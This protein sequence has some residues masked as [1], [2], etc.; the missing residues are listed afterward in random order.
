[1]LVASSFFLFIA[2]EVHNGERVLDTSMQDTLW[3]A[4]TKGQS[5][6]SQETFANMDTSSQFTK[7]SIEQGRSCFLTNKFSSTVT[8]IHYQTFILQSQEILQ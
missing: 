4:R 6:T 7:Y 5:Q 3:T 2:T 1:M 8:T